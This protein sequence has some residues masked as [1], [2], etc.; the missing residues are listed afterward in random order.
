MNTTTETT[1]TTKPPKRIPKGAVKLQFAGDVIIPILPNIKYAGLFKRYEALF[2]NCVGLSKQER[3]LQY[4]F[5]LSLILTSYAKK[6]EDPEQR[7]EIFDLKNRVYLDI[8]SG[9]ENRRF[10]SFRYL[11]S[12]NFRVLEFCDSCTKKNT[13]EKREKHSWRFCNN[14]KVDRNFYN[15]LCMHHRFDSGFYSIFLSNDLTDKIPF[16][17]KNLKKGK[18]EDTTEGGKFDKFHY[19]SKNMD[20]FDWPSVKKVAEKVLSK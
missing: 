16:R 12:K 18:L 7:K 6:T 8:C 4:K 9:A 10:L 5:V 15:V 11:Q 3:I 2:E 17:I 20:V 19:N 14:C 1:E 13:E